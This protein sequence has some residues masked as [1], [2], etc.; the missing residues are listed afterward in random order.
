MF[1]WYKKNMNII[2]IL[3]FAKIQMQYF[4]FYSAWEWQS[5]SVG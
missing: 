3:F 1:L 5:N 4:L 2:K